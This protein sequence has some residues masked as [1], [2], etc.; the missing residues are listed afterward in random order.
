MS[1]HNQNRFWLGLVSNSDIPP[2][3]LRVSYPHNILRKKYFL[4]KGCQNHIVYYIFYLHRETTIC[5]FSNSGESLRVHTECFSSSSKQKVMLVIFLT[6]EREPCMIFF[7]QLPDQLLSVYQ[8]TCGKI[9][10]H[11]SMNTGS[12]CAEWILYVLLSVQRG[13]VLYAPLLSVQYRESTVCP[14][15]VHSIPKFLVRTSGAVH[16]CHFSKSAQ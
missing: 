2:K 8:L 9:S 11:K 4:Q 14:S 12:I 7:H 10:F 16:P 13:W 5:P 1:C 3:N 15:Y 6:V